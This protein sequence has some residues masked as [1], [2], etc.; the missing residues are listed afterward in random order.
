MSKR[1]RRPS[2]LMVS[3]AGSALLPSVRDDLA[4]DL[5]TALDNQFFGGA[6]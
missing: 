1:S 5:D 3:V 2:T 4:V 6:P